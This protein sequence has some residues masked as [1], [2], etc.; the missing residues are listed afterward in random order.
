[1]N[2]VPAAALERRLLILAPVGRDADL[3]RAMLHK[4]GVPCERCSSLEQLV[5]ELQRGA[6]AILL[7]EEALAEQ[8]RRLAAAIAR[9]PPWSDLPVLLLTRSRAESDALAAALETLG[10]VTLLERPM[11]MES[12]AS[13]VR[14]ALRARE[15][16][17]QTRAHLEERELVNRR[18]DQFLA[19]LAH[20]LRN[21][22]APIRSS[23]A[24]LR[25][26]NAGA[27]AH[28]CEIMERQVSHMVRLVDD[29]MEVSRITRGKIELR[30]EAVDLA[31]VVTS[32][33]ETSR[34]LIDA[35]RHT[36][37]V[38]LPQEPVVVDADAIRLAQV[39]SN[40]LNNAA[41]YT[42]P[43][44]SIAISARRERDRA[45]VTVTDT[46]I[47]IPAHAIPGVFDMFAQVDARDRRAQS[48]LGIGLTLV[49]SLVEM[50]G[51]RVGAASDGPDRGS[52]FVVELPLDR[53]QAVRLTAPERAPEI[54]ELQR[55]L[56]VDDNEDAAVT[57]GALL[58]L[59]GVTVRTVNNGPA[60]LE[61]I[62]VFRPSVIVL[63]LGMPGMDGYEVARRVR[64]RPDGRDIALV[65][66]TG[67]GQEKDRELTKKAGFDHHLVKPVDIG[68]MRAVLATLT[69]HRSA[70][71]RSADKS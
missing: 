45:V 58:R 59:L 43:G 6:S 9:Q 55:I 19:T 11:R 71:V 4:D 51:G 13:A 21:P 8:D 25:L 66:L 36:L 20:E 37:A 53:R 48:G 69:R 60:A 26:E 2:A 18:K 47:G 3:I 7:A 49:R 12:L 35:A 68:T 5:V 67:W 10:N 27:S 40:L 50:H 31:T 23:L 29:L 34:P 22:L 30:R 70:A 56:V 33:V 14:S 52:R 15:R 32:A 64:Q 42:D 62:G 44:G 24:L 1:M 63:D 57:L 46:G 61:E 39:F 65:A 16:Q 54:G 38:T 28:V 41:K 17:Y